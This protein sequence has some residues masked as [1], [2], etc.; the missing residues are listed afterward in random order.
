MG[1]VAPLA[2]NRTA[3]AHED[4][5]RPATLQHG[6]AQLRQQLPAPEPVP[7]PSVAP[8]N[9]THRH[10]NGEPDH[11]AEFDTLKAAWPAHLT[12]HLRRHL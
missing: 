8:E 9:G 4:P 12:P 2:P 7:Y 6:F 11:G 3:Y 1:G 5:K 10:A